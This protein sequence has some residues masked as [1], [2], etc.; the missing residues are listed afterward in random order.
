MI[1]LLDPSTL[2]MFFSEFPGRCYGC[3]EPASFHNRYLFSCAKGVSIAHHRVT[4]IRAE[5]ATQRAAQQMA[6]N[7]I[8][9][10]GYADPW[11]VIP[12]QPPKAKLKLT[13]ESE[14]P[15]YDPQTGMHFSCKECSMETAKCSQPYSM[16][17]W[18]SSSAPKEE[19]I[20]SHSVPR[21]KNQASMWGWKDYEPPCGCNKCSGGLG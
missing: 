21:R 4:I 12:K 6:A 16:T 20:L 19:R 3:G 9:N 2:G 8:L 7:V 5:S 10:G 14:A 13:F 18:G 17:S 1:P 15:H 11:G